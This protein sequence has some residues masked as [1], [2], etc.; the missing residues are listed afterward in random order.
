MA[1]LTVT[2]DARG[3]SDP[4]SETIPTA[5]FYWYYRDE[6]GVDTPI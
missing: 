1:P 5:N 3:S 4:S 6:K 2:F